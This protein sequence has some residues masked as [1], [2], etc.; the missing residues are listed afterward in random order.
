MRMCCG[1]LEKLDEAV[2]VGYDQDALHT[3]MKFSKT[4]INP[5]LKIMPRENKSTE[6]PHV[7]N[8]YPYH[9]VTGHLLSGQN[10]PEQN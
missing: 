5:N 6:S 2:G 9:R 7:E 3:Y 1:L 8:F 10:E 4:Q